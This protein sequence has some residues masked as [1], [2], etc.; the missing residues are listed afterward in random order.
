MQSGRDIFQS[1]YGNKRALQHLTVTAQ[2]GSIL[3]KAMRWLMFKGQ[4][5]AHL[6]YMQYKETN[7]RATAS[8][9]FSPGFQSFSIAYT[10]YAR[11]LTGF[12]GHSGHRFPID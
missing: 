8:D 6:E 10:L 3:E 9:F 5:W 7:V 4:Q 2:R 12:T 1:K 11:D